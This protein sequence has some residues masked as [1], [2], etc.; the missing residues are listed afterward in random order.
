V[1]EVNGAE[2]LMAIDGHP[3]TIETDLVVASA[4]VND[5]VIGLADDLEDA[6]GPLDSEDVANS[7]G[8]LI[9]LGFLEKTVAVDHGHGLEEHLLALRLP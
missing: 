6:G 5:G 3:E 1:T 4:I 9:R 2:W 7:V 8:E